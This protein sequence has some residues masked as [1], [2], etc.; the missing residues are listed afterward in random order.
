MFWYLPACLPT[1]LPVPTYLEHAER[2]VKG[3]TEVVVTPM[4]TSMVTPYQYMVSVAE[5]CELRGLSRARY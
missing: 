3:G 1:Y 2:A 4:V 5:R